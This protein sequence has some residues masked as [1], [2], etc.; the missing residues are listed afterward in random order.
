[1]VVGF[2]ILF[3]EIMDWNEILLA[4]F[5]VTGWGFTIYWFIIVL[6]IFIEMFIVAGL[7]SFILHLAKGTIK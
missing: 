7:F 5:Y 3:A 6:K 1:M 4:P 2:L